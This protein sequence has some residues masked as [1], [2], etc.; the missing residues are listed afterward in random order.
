M[1]DNVQALRL[2]LE[3]LRA[4]HASGA[5]NDAQYAHRRAP[6]ERKLVDQVLQGDVAAGT[7]LPAQTGA[8]RRPGLRTW[9]ALGAFA[10]LVA[11]AGYWWT[12]MP[13]QSGQGAAGFAAQT[14]GEDGPEAPASAPHAMDNEQFAA[15]AARL[16]ARLKDQPD[17]V[18]GWIMLGRSYIAMGRLDEALP[19]FERAVKLKPNDASVLADMADALALQN[20]R[21]L[22]GEPMRLIERALKIEPGNLKALTLAGTEAFNRGDFAKAVEYWDR[23]AKVGPPDSPIV[24]QARN[25]AA[26]ARE[27]GKLPA[28]AA[29]DKGLPA[30][31]PASPAPALAGATGA[32]S[33]TVSLAPALKGKVAPDDAVFVFARAAEGSRMPLALVRKQ[34]KD[35]PFRF[36]LDDS[37]ALSPASRLSTAGS[38]IVGARISKS[39]QPMPQPGDLEGLSGA[40]AVGSQGVAV[41]I[42]NP[43]KQ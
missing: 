18:A 3:K 25:A 42:A 17:D 19:A 37:Q 4:Q 15:M 36:Q 39:G 7:G 14:E 40:T 13:D 35:L 6:L 5:I 29:N 16:A 21:D 20:N 43:I 1:T 31:T 28:A 32:V 26:E 38:V 30:A 41:V 8:E 34:V 11:G 12:R 23:A 33:G 2:Q 9:A 22:S 10:V 27:R 24:Q